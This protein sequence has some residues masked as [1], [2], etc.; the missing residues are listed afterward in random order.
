MSSYI[1]SDSSVTLRP[2][3][4]GAVAEPNL[5]LLM[6]PLISS[7]FKLPPPPLFIENLHLASRNLWP[8]PHLSRSR[9]FWTSS[10]GRREEQS[11]SEKKE[12]SKELNEMASKSE[13]PLSRLQLFEFGMRGSGWLSFW[14]DVSDRKRV[15]KE[16]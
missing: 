8:Q 7:S 16:L 11:K 14:N 2:S 6:T 3:S 13:F 15:E 9:I 10:S 1:Q 4:L 12:E 5:E